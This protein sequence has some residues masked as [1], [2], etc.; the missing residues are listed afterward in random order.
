MISDLCLLFLLTKEHDKA[1]QVWLDKV[2]L[3][4][5]NPSFVND[6]VISFSKKEKLKRLDKLNLNAF[7]N[8]IFFL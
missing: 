2:N 5:Q 3:V 1:G 4:N 6:E 7:T 8:L